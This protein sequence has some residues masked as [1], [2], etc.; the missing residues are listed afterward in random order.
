MGTKRPLSPERSEGDTR[1]RGQSAAGNSLV[2]R[3]AGR[4]QKCRHLWSAAVMTEA[5]IVVR[6]VKCGAREETKVCDS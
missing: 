4:W 1:R 5:L 6:C 2:T 3:Q